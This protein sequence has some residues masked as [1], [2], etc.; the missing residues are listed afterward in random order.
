MVEIMELYISMFSLIVVL[1]ALGYM[2]YLIA[3]C[4]VIIKGMLKRSKKYQKDI[5]KSIRANN[6]TA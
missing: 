3:G 1:G 5:D 2:L 6:D 4:K